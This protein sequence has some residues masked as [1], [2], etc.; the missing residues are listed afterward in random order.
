MLSSRRESFH[1]CEKGLSIL[2]CFQRRSLEH[3][4]LR[5]LSGVRTPG[6]DGGHGP[7]STDPTLLS[8]SSEPAHSSQNTPLVAPTSQPQDKCP[9]TYCTLHTAS[10]FLPK[11]TGLAG[12]RRFIYIL[13]SRRVVA[14]AASGMDFSV[15]W[16]LPRHSE[17]PSLASA[18]P[19]WTHK[20]TTHTNTEPQSTARGLQLCTASLPGKPRENNLL[21]NTRKSCSCISW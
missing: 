17:Y 15:L 21:Q 9:V 5:W 6:R 13:A 18:C 7:G 10:F 4:E 3:R 19:F 1:I 2:L 12:E 11:V 14:T 8:C 20:P 16:S